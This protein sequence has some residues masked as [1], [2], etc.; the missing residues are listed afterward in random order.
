[1]GYYSSMSQ[2]KVTL[3]SQNQSLMLSAGN[4]HYTQ[5][6]M[7]LLSFSYLMQLPEQMP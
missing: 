4:V 3:M 6:W 1:M 2:D 7:D 5:Q